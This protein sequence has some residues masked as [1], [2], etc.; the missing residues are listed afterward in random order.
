MVHENIGLPLPGSGR[1][2][3]C[4]V[5]SSSSIGSGSGL[6]RTTIGPLLC[7]AIALPHFQQN[8]YR[9]S[10][11]APQPSQTFTAGVSF[12][13]SMT[14][15]GGSWARGGCCAR[16]GSSIRFC[17]TGAG[18]A[19]STGGVGIGRGVGIGSGFFFGGS[20]ITSSSPVACNFQPAPARLTAAGRSEERRV[21]KECR[22]RW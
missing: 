21:G 3:C 14:R 18:G 17:A 1:T 2:S 16:G 13:G 11:D 20:G 12:L 7:D 8:A 5:N 9:D 15:G 10:I 4:T 22:S 19:T 6:L